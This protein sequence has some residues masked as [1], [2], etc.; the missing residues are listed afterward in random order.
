[1][2]TR[3]NASDPWDQVLVDIVTYTYHYQIESPRAWFHAR[4]A[5]IDALGCAMESQHA[6]AECRTLLGPYVPGTLVQNGCKVPGT[7][8][9]LDPIKGAFDLGASIRYLDHNDAIAGAEAGHPSGNSYMR[10]VGRT[11]L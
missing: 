4:T 3:D 7:T 10:L 8:F 11:L 9:Q 2:P 1:M 6:S 5:M